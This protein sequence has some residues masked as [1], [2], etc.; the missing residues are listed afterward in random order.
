MLGVGASP[1]RLRDEISKFWTLWIDQFLPA[2]PTARVGAWRPSRS[3]FNLHLLPRGII[4]CLQGA[5]RGISATTKWSQ[6]RLKVELAE[7]A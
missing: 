7:P 6:L 3:V 4:A 2:F 1:K 5:A